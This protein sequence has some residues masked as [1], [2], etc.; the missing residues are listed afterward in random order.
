MRMRNGRIALGVVISTLTLAGVVLLVV[1]LAL[2]SDSLGEWGSGV[3][4]NAGASVLLILPVYLL[5]KRLDDRIN[6]V[7]N[8]TRR[9]VSELTDRV[10]SFEQDMGRKLEDVAASVR[11][12]LMT[13]RK[14]DLVAFESLVDSP[15]YPVISEA[16]RRAD[17][18]GLIAR[19]RGPRVCVDDYWNVFIRTDFHPLYGIKFVA[20]TASG[21]ELNTVTWKEGQE[22]QEVLVRVGRAVQRAS[23]IESLDL[24]GFLAGLRH[25]LV[26]AHHD[27]YCRPIW[28]LCSPQWAV[29]PTHLVAYDGSGIPSVDIQRVFREQDLA[30]RMSGERWVDADSLREAVS[31]AAALQ[32]MDPPF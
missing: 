13:E 3:L 19:D 24:R 18:L 22:F 10:S 31:V 7:G 1:A 32:K 30:G 17:E 12:R 20:E 29:T 14:R 28:Q 9:S 27:P 16:L 23:D 6:R 15:N 21:T 8:E 4:V 5:T 11:E 2:T 25:C 26:V